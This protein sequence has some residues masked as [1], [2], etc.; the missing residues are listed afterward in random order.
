[1]SFQAEG[2]IRDR[3][4]TGVQTCALPSYD[5]EK[6]AFQAQVETMGRDTTL[7]IDTFDI[8]A[9]VRNAVDV[10]GS[11]LAF[12]RIDSGDLLEEAHNVRRLLDDL[13]Y[14]NTG[15]VVSSGLDVYA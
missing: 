1:F 6:T 4:V 12:V 9:G 8:E 15:I 2:G 3:N 5:D 7:L 14:T 11:E 13:G 10:A